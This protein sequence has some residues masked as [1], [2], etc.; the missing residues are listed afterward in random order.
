MKKQKLTELTM[1]YLRWKKKL[2]N[3]IHCSFSDKKLEKF[4]KEFFLE[5]LKSGI[6]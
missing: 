1:C 6:K 4:C 2:K 5:I 3:F